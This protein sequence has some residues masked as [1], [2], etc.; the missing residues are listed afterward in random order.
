[1]DRRRCGTAT[2]GCEERETAVGVAEDPEVARAEETAVLG[3][4]RVERDGKDGKGP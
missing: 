1:M 2:E 3:E 4:V